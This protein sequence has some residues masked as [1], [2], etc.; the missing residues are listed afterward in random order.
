[1]AVDEDRRVLEA[2]AFVEQDGILRGT[3]GARAGHAVLQPS[4]LQSLVVLPLLY[5]CC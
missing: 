4:V 1:M 2:V 5:R 3:T